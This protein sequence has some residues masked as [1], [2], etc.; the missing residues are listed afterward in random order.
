[1]FHIIHFYNKFYIFLKEFFIMGFLKAHGLKLAANSFV[2][3]AVVE[4]F[5]N[6]TEPAAPAD[7]G[8]IWLTY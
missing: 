1:M 7:A 4:T 2:Q 8:R 3:N 6:A 5:T